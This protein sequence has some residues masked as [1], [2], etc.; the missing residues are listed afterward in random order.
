MNFVQYAIKTIIWM[1]LNFLSVLGA[2]NFNYMSLYIEV[3]ICYEIAGVKEETLLA[4]YNVLNEL[5]TIN[6][7][8]STIFELQTPKLSSVMFTWFKSSW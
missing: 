4:I 2:V 1:V 5:K 6:C 7:D 3:T 8:D